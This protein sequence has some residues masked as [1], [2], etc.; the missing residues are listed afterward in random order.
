MHR[1]GLTTGCYI[2]A[3]RTFPEPGAENGGGGKQDL[4]EAEELSESQENRRIFGLTGIFP[5][6][7]ALPS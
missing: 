7:S 5:P 2:R 4:R 1:F 3:F 6:V